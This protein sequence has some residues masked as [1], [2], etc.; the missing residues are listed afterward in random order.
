MQEGYKSWISKREWICPWKLNKL[1]SNKLDVVAFVVVEMQCKLWI[2]KVR[3]W[4]IDYIHEQGNW[5][6]E[7]LRQRGTWFLSYLEWTNEKVKSVLISWFYNWSNNHWCCNKA[8]T[9]IS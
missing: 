8:Y 4:C 2:H 9:V 1:F 3:K 6:V 7:E 5:I